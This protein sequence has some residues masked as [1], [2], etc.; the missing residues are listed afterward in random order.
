MQWIWVKLL[1]CSALCA[2]DGVPQEKKSEVKLSAGL[3]VKTMLWSACW[4]QIVGRAGIEAKE[5]SNYLP[6]GG[7]KELKKFY[8]LSSDKVFQVVLGMYLFFLIE[9]YATGDITPND[10]DFIDGV[11]TRS[12]EG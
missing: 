9:G 1:F 4:W 12:D 2:A 8:E 5:L 11:G 6:T 10:E 7:A 3:L